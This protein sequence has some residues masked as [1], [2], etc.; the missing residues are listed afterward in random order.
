[1]NIIIKLCCVAVLLVSMSSIAPSNA[2][3][4]DLC[5]WQ[6]SQNTLSCLDMA[7]SCNGSCNFFNSLLCGR[8]CNNHLHECLEIVDEINARCVDRYQSY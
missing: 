5:H 3:A 7:I 2:K 6:H 8:V 1:M 4:L